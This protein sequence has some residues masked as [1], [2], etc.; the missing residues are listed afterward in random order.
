VLKELSERETGYKKQRGKTGLCLEIQFVSTRLGQSVLALGGWRPDVSR[1]W[2]YG[3]YL[4]LLNKQYQMR[5][6]RSRGYDVG[7]S[8]LIA[9]MNGR[10]PFSSH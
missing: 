4:H 10:S 1:G 2:G 8:T 3:L 6:A 7:P 9:E 5:L